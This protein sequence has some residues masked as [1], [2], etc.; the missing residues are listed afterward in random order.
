[1]RAA[2]DLMR[3][4][5]RVWGAFRGEDSF[6]LQRVA[7]RAFGAPWAYPGAKL[8][9][10]FCGLVSFDGHVYLLVVN[11]AHCHGLLAQA[12]LIITKS[13]PSP[14]TMLLWHGPF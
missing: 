1:M 13:F 12:S 14:G 5:L 6:R 8:G 7:F 11:P 4:W 9:A 3:L 10:D 2:L